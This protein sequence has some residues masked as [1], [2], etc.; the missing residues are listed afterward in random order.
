MI[1]RRL[2]RNKSSRRS[3][4]TRKASALCPRHFQLLCRTYSRGRFARGHLGPTLPRTLPHTL[5]THYAAQDP[6]SAHVSKERPL[7]ATYARMPC[8]SFRRR[9]TLVRI[10][11][12]P[13]HASPLSRTQR[14]LHSKL[15]QVR[16]RH[17]HPSPLL[18][19]G[20]PLRS[21]HPRKHG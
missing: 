2:T 14:P 5:R 13:H 20:H 11:T 9:R 8:R 16:L 3:I 4:E 18:E 6:P 19:S 7:A 15:R 12:R 17:P 1:K 10:Y 21:P